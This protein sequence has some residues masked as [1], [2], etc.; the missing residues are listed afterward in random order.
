M[1]V[2]YGILRALPPQAWEM[3]LKELLAYTPGQD[4]QGHAQCG[5]ILPQACT[6]VITAQ[7]VQ[8]MRFG[9]QWTVGGKQKPLYNA[10]A[11]TI[12]QRAAFRPLMERGQRCLLPAAYFYEWAQDKTPYLFRHSDYQPLYMAGL[13]CI[14][15]GTAQFV[16]ITT[17]ADEAVSPIHERMPLIIDSAE[18]REAWLHSLPLAQQVLALPSGVS[19][20]AQPLSPARQQRLL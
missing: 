9:L 16:I 20:R 13:Y 7:G 10:R 12:M 8:E 6:P 14:Q 4:P 18:Y 15:G 1:C 3:A 19:L 11:E 2:K 17:A 5:T